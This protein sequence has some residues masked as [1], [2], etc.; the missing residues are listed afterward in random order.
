M[1]NP[2]ICF[3]LHE[4]PIGINLVKSYAICIGARSKI[5]LNDL[6]DIKY[7]PQDPNY[8][9]YVLKKNTYISHCNTA[10]ADPRMLVKRVCVGGNPCHLILV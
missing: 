9:D 8:S 6:N 2:K 10:K 4:A 7:F 5:N 3:H 1:D